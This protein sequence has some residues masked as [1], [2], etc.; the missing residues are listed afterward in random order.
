MGNF[1]LFMS[2]LFDDDDDD[3]EDKFG[4]NFDESFDIR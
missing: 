3:G 1:R 4:Q 2:I